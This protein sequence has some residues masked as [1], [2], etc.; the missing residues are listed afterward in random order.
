[1]GISFQ[2]KPPDANAGDLRTPVVFYACAPHDGPEP[3]ESQKKILHECF[4]EVYNPSMKD[5]EVM[6]ATDTKEAVTIRI[7]DTAG[8]FTP[9][10]KHYV[11][12]R[13]YRYSGKVFNAVDVRYDLKRN[14]FTTI[15]LGCS[16]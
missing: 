10:N 11:E 7:R 15:L 8:E 5:I 13:D 3:G 9:T 4:A 1:M 12:I 2:Y 6:K 14:G 16:T